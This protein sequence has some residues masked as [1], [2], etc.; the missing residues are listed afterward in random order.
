MSA[1][2]APHLPDNQDAA[3]HGDD[4]RLQRAP[5]TEPR[6]EPRTDA[7]ELDEPLGG[8]PPCWLHLFDDD[9]AGPPG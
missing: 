8:D 2:S 9:D 4:I 5:A 3:P 7:P 1:Q 6:S